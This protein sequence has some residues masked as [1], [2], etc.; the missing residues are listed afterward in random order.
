MVSKFVSK[1]R[2]AALALGVACVFGSAASAAPITYDYNYTISGGTDAGTF[3][4]DYDA[5]SYGV[6][7][8]SVTGS[9]TTDGTLGAIT[10][11]KIT[12]WE[13]TLTG[14]TYTQSISSQMLFGTETYAQ[15]SFYATANTLTSTGAYNFYERFYGYNSDGSEYNSL[16]GQVFGNTS[17]YGDYAIAYRLAYDCTNSS[18]CTYLSVYGEQAGEADQ[19]VYNHAVDFKGV[20]SNG[21]AVVPLPAGLP[22]VLTG[23]GALVLLRRRKTT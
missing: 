22:L 11:S 12:A 2:T 14:E 10:Q 13:F 7:E 5:N 17:Y 15:G 21:A 3:H 20:V 18:N 23:F 19:S 4:Y 16:I 8:I 1:C 6:G 9:I